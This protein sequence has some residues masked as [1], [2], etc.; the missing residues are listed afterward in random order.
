[1]ESDLGEVALVVGLDR[2]LELALAVR[3]LA[4]LLLLEAFRQDSLV[5]VR[6]R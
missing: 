6:E 2:H 3:C 4:L 1:M 5:A